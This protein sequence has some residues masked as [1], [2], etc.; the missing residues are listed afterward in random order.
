MF[1]LGDTIGNLPLIVNDNIF[2]IE[3]VGEPPI[4]PKEGKNMRKIWVA[5]L[6][7]VLVLCFI[8]GVFA[9][10]TVKIGVFFPMTE[11]LEAYARMAGYG[12]QLAHKDRPMVLA[13]ITLTGQSLRKLKATGITG[14]MLKKLNALR[15]KSFTG[16]VAFFETLDPLLKETL[17]P[18]QHDRI[19]H[20]RSLILEHAKVSGGKPVEL[21]QIRGRDEREQSRSLVSLIKEQRLAAILGGMSVS[22][23]ATVAKIAEKARLPLLSP[24]LTDPSFMR[25]ANYLFRVPFNYAF[26]GYV[27]ALFA[28]EQFGAKTAAVMVDTEQAVSQNMAK[29]FGHYFSKMGSEFVLD[30]PYRTGDR[31]FRKQLVAIANR[32][33]DVIYIPGYFTEVARIARQIKNMGIS[34]PLLSSDLAHA[35][36]LLKLGGRAVE[37]LYII[38]H[39]QRGRRNALMPKDARFFELFRQ[40]ERVFPPSITMLFWDVYNILLDAIEETGSTNPKIVRKTLRKIKDYPGATGLLTLNQSF[41]IVENM[42]ALTSNRNFSCLVKPQFSQY[43][44]ENLLITA[45]DQ[46]GSKDAETIWNNVYT[47]WTNAYKRRGKKVENL[48]KGELESIIKDAKTI[49]QTTVKRAKL[50]DKG[51]SK[52]KLPTIE[53]KSPPVKFKKIERPRLEDPNI[54]KKPEPP[55]LENPNIMPGWLTLDTLKKPKT[56]EAENVLTAYQAIRKEWS[57]SDFSH[58]IVVLQVKNRA[59]TYARTIYPASLKFCTV[60]SIIIGGV[61]CLEWEELLGICY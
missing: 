46:A 49:V 9:D 23:T 14:R 22:D 5:L 26:Q 13:T 7:Y 19:P 44:F 33:P 24:Y 61:G 4:K 39:F 40:R 32:K 38:P 59:F 52:T 53:M 20:Y 36:E 41:R 18:R 35:S 45:V 29:A 28:R 1:R 17:I 11:R 42:W 57:N 56:K 43:V 16:R 30:I 47:L 27:T 31:D 12:L 10:E 25:K 21:L 60:T 55:K 48:R 15:N 2:M 8:Q 50:P 58:G 51:K 6:I 54:F 3:V 34:I 37:D